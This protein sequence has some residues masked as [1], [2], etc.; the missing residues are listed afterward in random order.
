LINRVNY[1]KKNSIMNRVNNYEIES[2]QL[3]SN[4]A[5]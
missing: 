3:F 1:K 5:F 2:R 4:S